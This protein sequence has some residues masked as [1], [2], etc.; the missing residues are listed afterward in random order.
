MKRKDRE[1]GREFG[2]SV[3]EEARLG[4]LSLAEGDG[5]AYGVPLSFTRERN[6]L[7]FHSAR[8]GKKA[9]LIR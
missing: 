1:T 3:I 6:T 4:V 9:E 5:R 7:H 2:H 8:E